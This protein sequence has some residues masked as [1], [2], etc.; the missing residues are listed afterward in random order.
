[1][2]TVAFTRRVLWGAAATVVATLG[3]GRAWSR[4]AAAATPEPDERGISISN[5]AIHQEVIFQASPARVYQCLTDAAI[6]QK[7][8]VLSGAM[9]TMD[10][11]SA[12]AR[13]SLEPGG[14]FTLFGSYITGRQ[15]EL[16]PGVR[17][18]Q[19]WRSAGWRPHAYSIAR[20]EI[21]DHADGAKLV[22]DHVGFPNDDAEGLAAGWREHYWTPMAKVLAG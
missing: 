17:I 15:L 9:K 11:Q 16:E 12:P 19:V 20:F 22:F 14:A 3:S 1:M 13:I 6:F 8:V 7:V 18:V 10:L 5:A 2:P 4:D 21:A